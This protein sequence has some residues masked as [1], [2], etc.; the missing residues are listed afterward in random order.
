MTELLN[1]DARIYSL[2]AE[3]N[4][5]DPSL[6]RPSHLA[7]R[8]DDLVGLYVRKSEITRQ[9]GDRDAATRNNTM[10]IQT[11]RLAMA[12]E[13]TQ[14]LESE[15]VGTNWCFQGARLAWRSQAVGDHGSGSGTSIPTLIDSLALDEAIEAYDHA[16][17]E[18]PSR[19]S[20]LRREAA[21]NRANLLGARFEVNG[22]EADIDDAIENGEAALAELI[23]LRFPSICNDVGVLYQQRGQLYNNVND[24][25]RAIELG[26]ISLEE[27]DCPQ[28][29]RVERSLN[30]YVSRKHLYDLTRQTQQLQQARIE[31]LAVANLSER[32]RGY[33]RSHLL[34]RLATLAYLL[35]VDTGIA[36]YQIE[37]IRF[38]QEGLASARTD[39]ISDEHAELI[40][41]MANALSHTDPQGRSAEELG[42][43]IAD[44]GNPF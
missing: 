17:R 16:L 2:E 9:P 23:S 4:G 25:Q 21:L 31:L 18:L 41:V 7:A 8:Y 13:Y 3:I 24:L 1:I 36:E 10:A 6:V 19:R 34:G 30:L 11:G 5:C 37:A 26:L 44:G 12:E 15:D 43:I 32:G 33:K 20:S 42:S 40:L 22:A 38:A 14:G 39:G 29:I 28:R 27:A 35:S